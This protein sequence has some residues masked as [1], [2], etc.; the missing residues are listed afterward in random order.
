MSQV[1][2]ADIS[3]NEVAPFINEVKE[4]VEKLRD[5][6]AAGICN[7]NAELLKAKGEVM[8]RE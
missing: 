5:G 2:D 4:A 7:I 8:I 3:I 1:L 6:K